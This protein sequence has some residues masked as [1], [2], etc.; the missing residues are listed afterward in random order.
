[1]MQQPSAMPL[2]PMQSEPFI[3]YKESAENKEKGA[4]LV[5]ALVTLLVMTL[6]GVA[7]M[8][9]SLTDL[10]STQG[11]SDADYA[12]QSA[13]TGLRIAESIINSSTSDSN[14]TTLLAAANISVQASDS[15]DYNSI[16]FWDSVTNYS[17]A[18]QLKIVVE[19]YQTV[20]DSLD[21]SNPGKA[22][23]YYKVTA[24]GDDPNQSYSSV[25]VQSIY[26][27]RYD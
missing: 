3:G 25:V 5:V 2:P 14:A 21:L 1:M 12:F 4:A 6:L 24:R 20:F 26:A 15:G 23:W 18:P 19:H 9:N 22:I 8:K 13:E 17:T 27:K 7:S 16:T 11:Y 10:Y